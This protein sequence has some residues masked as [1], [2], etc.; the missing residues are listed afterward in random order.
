MEKEEEEEII[1]F[2]NKKWRATRIGAIFK[3]WIH[4]KWGIEQMWLTLAEPFHM[5]SY[6]VNIKNVML[7]RLTAAE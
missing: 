2:M 5:P 3:H 7:I 6:K 1:M 4:L